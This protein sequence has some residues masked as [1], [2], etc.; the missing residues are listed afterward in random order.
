MIMVIGSAAWGEEIR[1]PYASTDPD[2]TLPTLKGPHSVGVRSFAWVDEARLETASPKESDYREVTVQIWYPATVQSADRSALYTPELKQMFSAS[3]SLP[4]REREFVKAHEV[5]RNTA[6]NS[7]PGAKILNS[8]Q[9]WPVIL[10]SPGGNVSRHSQTVLAER[11]ASQGFVFVSMSHPFSTMDVAPASGFSMSIDW[12]LDQEDQRAATEADNRLA[13]IL[14]GDAAFVLHQLH[15]LVENDDLFDGALELRHVGIAG[16]SRGG[17]TVG[18]ACASNPNIV[19]CAVIDNIGPDRERET[20]VKPP[21]LTLRAPWAD[22]RIAILHD[23]LG[24]TGSVAYD[25]VL[26]GSNHFTCTDL[27]LFM[28]DL[29][30]AGI[31]P[32]DGID[33][34][35]NI[36]TGFFDAYLR[37]RISTDDNTWE[38][39]IRSDKVSITKF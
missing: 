37:R 4:E 3:A 6:T 35:A 23:Y 12:G 22:E 38:Q 1:V 11:M 16:H 7:V 14:A 10:F 9:P 39:N 36:L 5:L 29:R 24:R 34:C 30:V 20:G 26:A 31:E 17:T 15:K 28:L 27:P 18:R 2:Y 25:V 13:Q 19:A 21:F 8:V 33:A 32:V